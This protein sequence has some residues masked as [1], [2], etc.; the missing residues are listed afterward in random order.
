MTVPLPGQPSAPRRAFTVAAVRHSPV[1][2]GRAIHAA[3]QGDRDAQHVLAE[4]AAL[5][6]DHGPESKGAA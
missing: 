4:L 6:V 2:R 3:Q 1:E 5:L